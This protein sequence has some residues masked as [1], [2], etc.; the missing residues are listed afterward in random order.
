MPHY[1]TESGDAAHYEVETRAEKLVIDYLNINIF[2]VQE[3]SIDIY[4]YFMRE[5]YIY[6]L[7]QTK[8]GREYLD[9]CWRMEQTKPDRAKIR[10]RI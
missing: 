9:N 8:E 4:L 5:A 2:D 1:Q 10:E 7:E 6:R 3:M